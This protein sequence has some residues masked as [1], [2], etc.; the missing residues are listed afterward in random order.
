M[1]V[2][3]LCI[4]VLVA[5]AQAQSFGELVSSIKQKLT[6]TFTNVVTV[7]KAPATSLLQTLLADLKASGAQLL[8]TGL[9]ALTSK[10]GST[11]TTA[12]GSR[13]EVAEIGHLIEVA[14][15]F[16]HEQADRVKEL[17]SSALAELEKVVPEIVDT[18]FKGEGLQEIF[19]KIDGIEV[20]H[21][22]LQNHLVDNLGGNLLKV[23]EQTIGHLL[24]PKRSGITDTLASFGQ[25]LA[26]LF[27]PVQ[28]AVKQHVSTVA[29]GIKTLGSALLGSL[30]GTFAQ[31][32]SS[33]T[34]H[35]AALKTVG[36]QLVQH[37]INALSASKDALS[38][39][40]A[41]TF[42]NAQ[43]AVQTAVNTLKD[44]A[45]VVVQNVAQHLG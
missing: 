43:P 24:S 32:K 16:L 39:V 12:P 30:A 27:K 5:G 25:T 15:T 34:P 21:G 14:Q 37:G 11:A 8:S 44:A 26:A 31:L 40:L 10:L 18:L 45:G 35:I 33:L 2:L 23:A 17:A 3:I 28:D 9:V 7:L 13:R 41:Q 38:D 1:K 19:K 36:A 4:A 20:L 29:S 42:Q 22:L 6:D